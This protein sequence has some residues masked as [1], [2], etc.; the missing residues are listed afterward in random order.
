MQQEGH[1]VTIPGMTNRSALSAGLREIVAD[2]KSRGVDLSTDPRLAEAILLDSFPESPAEIHALVEAIRSGAIQYMTDRAPQG[3]EFSIHGSASQLTEG[4]GLREDLARWAVQS[5]WNALQLGPPIDMEPES[6]EAV[7]P[8]P[9]PPPPPPAPEPPPVTPSP[10]ESPGIPV[11]GAAGIA[12]AAGALAGSDDMTQGV[13]DLA[14]A[15]A[16]ATTPL[17]QDVPYQTPPQ[18]P[19]PPAGPEQPVG[20]QQ[21]TGAQPPPAGQQYTGQQYTGQQ[22]TGQQYTG[23]Q[24]TGQQGGSQ[25]PPTGGPGL[26]GQGGPPQGP[27]QGNRGR[28]LAA[29]AVVVIILAYV[30]IAAGAKLP[31]FAKS[32]TTTTT[33]SSTT[34]STTPPTSSTTTTTTG[35]TPTTNANASSTLA[36]AIPSSFESACTP[37]S[38]TEVKTIGN[39]AEASFSCTPDT[40]LSVLYTIYSTPPEAKSTYNGIITEEVPAGLQSGSCVNGNDHEGN[41]TPTND[42]SDVIGQIACFTDKSGEQELL[43]YRHDD[44]I[45]ALALSSSLT[46]K[47]ELSDWSSLGPIQPT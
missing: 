20:G 36:N 30:G 2:Y 38:A 42:T 32:A 37:V 6:N 10:I 21:Y 19:G 8:P 9:P 11:A 33:T 12:A 31:P 5:W 26:V 16:A 46:L 17:P 27:K 1:L 15:A 39:G 4:A 22:Y 24:Y 23:Q 25:Y 3:L 44:N 14:P 40:G 18:T 47:K 13:D 7:P 35:V 34:S 45:V 29:G 41:Y 28:F 43:W